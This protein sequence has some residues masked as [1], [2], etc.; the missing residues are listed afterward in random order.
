MAST[1]TATGDM[2][3]DEWA[4]IR[5]ALTALDR[6]TT[7]RI[8]ADERNALRDA[9]R[10]RAK[11]DAAVTNGN[12]MDAAEQKHFEDVLTKKIHPGQRASAPADTTGSCQASVGATRAAS[13]GRERGR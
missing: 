10:M 9:L 2:A 8:N 7:D 6:S 12:D 4:R 1:S 11:M 13:Q 3:D 5:R